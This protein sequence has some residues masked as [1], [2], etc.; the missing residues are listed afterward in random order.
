[1]FLLGLLLPIRL[2]ST[3]T[4][5]GTVSD[6]SG[7]AIS[8][9]QVQL[10]FGDHLLAETKTSSTGEFVLEFPANG[11]PDTEFTL[12]AVASGFA[13]RTRTVRSASLKL[14]LILEIAPYLQTVEIRAL[15]PPNEG[16]LDMSGVRE[17][18][19]R[20]VG[21]ALT[22]LEGIWKIR[23]GGIANDVVIRGFQQ[24]NIN[25]LVD[26]SRTY[27]ACPDHQDPP[28]EHI[29]FAEVDH[30]D[31]NRGAFD[32]SNQGSLGAV[33]N[34]VTKSPSLGFSLK[35]AFGVG[36]FDFYNPSITA[37]YGNHR[38]RMLGGYSYRS[39]DPYKDGSAHPFTSY[40]N[41]SATGMQQKAFDISTG[42]IEA[43]LS[44]S[45][46]QQLSI[47]YTRQQA[48]LILYPYLTMDSDHDNADR[49]L[50]KYSDKNLSS[51]FRNILV[52]AYFTQVQ[53]AMSDSQRTTAMMG[54][55]SMAAD[56]ASRTVGGRA[57]VDLGRDATL[58][59][60]SYNRNWNM[61]D[62]MRMSGMVTVTPGIPDA[63]TQTFGSFLS[64]HHSLSE[65]WKLTA[66]AR[67]DHARMQIQ[68][69]DASTDLYYQF[70]GTQR[71]ANLD[72][73]PSGNLQ[74]S[75]AL[76]KSLDW[77]AGAGTTGR[78]PDAQERYINLPMGMGT[79]S[80]AM[81]GNPLLPITRDTEFSTGINLH[82]PWLSLRPTFF[83]SFLD[84]FI[85]VNN[86]TQMTVPGE[87]MGGMT[88]PSPAMARSF[89]NVDAHIYGG[90][91]TYT[92]PLPKSF[93][94]SGGVSYTRGIA[95]TNPSANVMSN[96][97]P[98]MPPLRARSALRYTRRWTFA[99]IGAV[100]SD[101]Q[102][103]VD[104]DL[105]E[106]PTAGY[107]LMDLKLGFTYRK[108]SGSFTLENMLDRFYSEYLSYYRDPFASGVKIPEPGRNFFL[109][110]RYA[111]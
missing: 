6:S 78:I 71:T 8:G 64:Y 61:L 105:N 39:S 110:L 67:Y 28:A 38:F 44:L 5:R 1:L 45:D 98:E 13:P 35:P 66:G 47:E 76:L 63:N 84:N 69:S 86:Q 77:F 91:L 3:E 19:A 92:I 104:T 56:A 79:T 34:I 12:M 43:E 20:D 41:Y 60:E 103:H 24:N 80:N 16:V 97:L 9:A 48:G 87:T 94:L 50:L 18:A 10:L 7:A 54:Q 21:E 73:Y 33:V 82:R 17:S 37:S 108:F 42:W 89:T 74:I 58:G 70:H 65:R 102:S 90:E 106:T 14:T 57:E 72:N 32:V 40:A 83:Y 31:V 25:L 81:V 53:H 30:V 62:F 27:G 95:S 15:T 100:A 99:E 59:L 11:S 22:D 2:P 23:K 49:G 109:H 93:A 55:W 52:E 36:S 46:R 96:N 88:M 26:G 111:F 107:A 51:L 101:R 85:L 29:D 4:I 75:S 68:A